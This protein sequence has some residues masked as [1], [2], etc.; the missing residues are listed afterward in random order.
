MATFTLKIDCGNAAFGE[1]DSE[2]ADEIAR[3]LRHVASDV[4]CRDEGR[5][6]DLNGNVVGSWKISG[7]RKPRKRAGW[8]PITTGA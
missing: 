5:T 1:T 2:R 4:G 8:R 7:A 6:V 3:I